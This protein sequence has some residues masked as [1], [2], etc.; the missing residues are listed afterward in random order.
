MDTHKMLLRSII[1]GPKIMTI[2]EFDK[3]FNKLSYLTKEKYNFVNEFKFNYY[4]EVFK[5]AV[6]HGLD[7][8]IELGFSESELYGVFA[9]LNR[10]YDFEIS[11]A[12]QAKLMN[13]CDA[14]ANW[15][16]EN[17]RTVA[18]NEVLQHDAYHCLHTLY[19]TIKAM[20]TKD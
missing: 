7:K 2:T 16:R 15:I 10:N 11:K 5:V 4:K 8:L 20:K 13:D 6:E 18:S 17:V 19:S 1:A 14:I 9:N 12:E 3:N